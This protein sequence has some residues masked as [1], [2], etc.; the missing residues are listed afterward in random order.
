MLLYKGASFCYDKIIYNR[1]AR[2]I[3]ATVNK[4]V[5]F[6]R[7]SSLSDVLISL[8]NLVRERED[9][10]E[11]SMSLEYLGKCLENFI[12]ELRDKIYFILL[13]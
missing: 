4:N 12:V 13:K 11:I 2:K 7:N 8:G 5:N 3:I 6:L 9:F 10:K 1:V